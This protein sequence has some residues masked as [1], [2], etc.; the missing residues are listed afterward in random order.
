MVF[1]VEPAHTM[2]EA[3]E[4]EGDAQERGSSPTSSSRAASPHPA[5]RTKRSSTPDFAAGYYALVCFLP[6]PDGTPHAFD[7]MATAFTVE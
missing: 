7:G 5:G 3:L 6:G 4:F 2:Q 1:R